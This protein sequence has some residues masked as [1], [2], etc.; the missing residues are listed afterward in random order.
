MAPEPVRAGNVHAR[1]DVCAL[2]IVLYET[3]AA[4]RLFSAGISHEIFAT[5]RSRII[6]QAVAWLD[7][8][9]GRVQ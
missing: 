5:K 9:P 2:G 3:I 7:E 6:H 4:R 8:F 1:S